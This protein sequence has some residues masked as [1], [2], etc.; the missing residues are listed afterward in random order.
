[1]TEEVHTRPLPPNGAP[2]AA[3]AGPTLMDRV[4]RALEGLWHFLSS[5]RTAMVLMLA[6][7][8]L[9]V[10]GSLVIQAPPGVLVSA[11]A[12]ANWLDEIRPK[13]GG[14]TGFLDTIQMFE[15][16]NSI[17]FR[18]L[19]AGLT[20][21]L[22]ACSIHR[23]PGVWRTTTK[24]RV[25]VGPQFFEHAPQHEAIVVRHTPAET[26]AIVESVMR[27]RHYRFLSTD[28]GAI[29]VY[30][31]R[32]RYA[33]WAGLIAHVSIV[34]ILAGAIIGGMFGYRDAGFTIA[35]GQTLPVVAE[36]GLEVQLIDFTDKYDTV[37]GSPIDYASQI[38]VFKDG[39]EIDRH[40]VRVNDPYRYGDL[41]FYQAFF[42]AAAVMKIED[43]AGE[44]LYSGG[45]PLAWRT[46]ADNRPVGSFTVP[47][48]GEVIWLV[49]TLGGGDA[50]IKPGQ[51]Q[52]ELYTAGEGSQIANAT[53]DQGVATK[54]GDL[55]VTFERETQFTGLNVARDP[56][57]LLVWLGSLLLFG[58]FSI[59]F[60]IRH[61]RVWGRIVARPN[62]GSVLGMATLATK[63]V[64][65][66][67]EF[68]NLVTD[69]RAAL[70]TPAQS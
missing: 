28:D 20:I 34:V 4:D 10:V 33:A 23:I 42:G 66:A 25:D 57:V 8:A 12:K 63:D 24:P 22:I 52:A 51:I 38:V 16:F 59:R 11:D 3:A 67:T 58:G 48:A 29:H 27:G 6:I 17:L 15:V 70:Q 26:L 7:A 47:G 65:Q 54:L 31:D 44:V 68:E 40:T 69:I 55:T 45:V 62:G 35:E 9:G 18:I 43:A 14:W 60:M 50:T 37:T 2:A 13:Y 64:S 19:V 5:M 21:S 61:K 39:T 32:F 1:M 36:P 46:N 56:G 41:T 49:G 30:G 53:I